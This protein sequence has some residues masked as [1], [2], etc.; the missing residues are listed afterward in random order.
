MGSG[1]DSAVSD[2]GNGLGFTAGYDFGRRPTGAALI[3]G[4]RFDG[5]NVEGE[6]FGTAALFLNLAFK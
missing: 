1:G 4:L 6:S 2:W 3:L 5:M